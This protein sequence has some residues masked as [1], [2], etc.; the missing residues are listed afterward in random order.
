VVTPDYDLIFPQQNP[1]EIIRILSE[2]FPQEA[3]GIRGLMS[4]L[5][6]L[7]QELRKPIDPKTI[8]STHPVMWSMSNQTAAQFMDKYLQDPK[9]KTILSAVGP[10]LGCLP[11]NS[12]PCLWWCNGRLYGIG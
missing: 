11:Q 2:K 10:A 5:M 6:N 4:Q 7:A 12:Q 9:L 1:K 3:E 8:S